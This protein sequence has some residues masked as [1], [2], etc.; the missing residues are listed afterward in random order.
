MTTTTTANRMQHLVPAS[1]VLALAAGVTFLSFTQ[2]PA[3]AFLF[4]RVIAVAMLVLAVWNF[5]RAALGLARVGSGV[6]LR[7][8]LNILPGL[9]VVV[10]LIFAGLTLLGFYAASFL[11]FL[12]IYTIY[13]P[14]PLTHGGGWLRRIAV[15]AAFMMV[16][17]ALFARLLQVQT[18]QGL[19]F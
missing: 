11:G 14:V 16:I 12:A 10:A 2:E 1:A 5:A 7:P 18:P 4:P 19:L 17:Y 13:D 8:F 15:S 3:E 6:S 9:A